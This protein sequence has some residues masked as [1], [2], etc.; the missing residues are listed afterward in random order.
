MDRYVEILEFHGAS[1]NFVD[2]GQQPE[3]VEVEG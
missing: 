1:E 2:G 3:M